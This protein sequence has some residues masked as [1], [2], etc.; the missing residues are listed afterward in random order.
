[1]A[2]S[3][4]EHPVFDS[5]AEQKVWH[6]LMDSLG[7][8]DTIVCNYRF[9]HNRRDHE[10]DFIVIRPGHGL[11]V[12]EVKGGFI[13]QNAEGQLFSQDGAG[14]NHPI[15]PAAQTIR[16]YNAL[17]K[18]VKDRW[19]NVWA[20]HFSWV[21]VFP[22]I[23]NGASFATPALVADRIVDA[24][25]LPALDS[26]I[27]RLAGFVDGG[28]YSAADCDLF[29]T[30]LFGRRDPIRE[31]AADAARREEQVD[32]WTDDQKRVL[33]LASNF[34][35]FAVVGPAGSGKTFVAI[36]QARRLATSG[37]R[38]ALLCYTRGLATYLKAITA[39]W[40]ANS[41][42]P[43]VGTFHS[44]ASQWGVRAPKGASDEWWT[45]TCP[46]EMLKALSNDSSNRFELFDAIVVDEAQD[47]AEDWWTVLTQ[48]LKPSKVTAPLFVFGASDQ[49]VFGR[50]G[51]DH[52][53][54]PVLTLNE[55]LR[56]TKPIAE[57]ASLLTDTPPRILGLDGPPVRFVQSASDQDSIN[58]TASDVAQALLNEG[59]NFEDIALLKT[60]HRH[61]I[62]REYF[63]A[64]ANPADAAG[65]QDRY[66]R[67]FWEKN[68]LFYGTVGGFK[69]LERRVAV[70]GV[71]GFRPTDDP[72]DVMYVA[73]TRARDLLVIVGDLAELR[74]VL[75]D[76]VA[77]VLAAH[78]MQLPGDDE[79][80]EE[81][82]ETYDS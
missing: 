13:N 70:I 73:A 60:Q 24:N 35:A 8:R 79:Y 48:A 76:R 22:D 82:L 40:P 72:Q 3:I 46:R 49:Q 45:T 47:F 27:S 32:R 67:S 71:D 62:Q 11:T 42:L 57:F 7:K 51:F 12:V 59:W 39:K 33:D 2:I 18:M 36:E 77:D 17:S 5:A 53:A 19:S 6:Q 34:A 38:V 78:P 1:M 9:E 58:A 74:E 65:Q 61:D 63:P 44:L 56:C 81:Y 69:G 66:W 30:A 68:D 26:V 55:N 64:L 16:N 75:G 20:P 50:T 41:Q 43:F 52:L 54:L 23:N 14:E 10:I 21:V 15:D 4:P 37:K 29:K 28:N 25:S 80:S 31:W